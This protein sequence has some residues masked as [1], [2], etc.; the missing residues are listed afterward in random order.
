MA[1]AFMNIVIKPLMLSIVGTRPAPI[2]KDCGLDD[3]RYSVHALILT[4]MHTAISANEWER[5]MVL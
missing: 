5:F 2:I 1:L 4:N 3:M